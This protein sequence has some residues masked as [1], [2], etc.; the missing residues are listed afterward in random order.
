MDERE[1]PRRFRVLL[2]ITTLLNTNQQALGSF[3]R[4]VPRE[5]SLDRPASGADRAAP[6]VSP[7]RLRPRR[8]GLRRLAARVSSGRVRFDGRRDRAVGVVR[9]PQ[10]VAGMERNNPEGQPWEIDS[11]KRSPVVQAIAG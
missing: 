4:G 5:D 10:R 9:G 1:E 7:L 3:E 8:R 11:L 6:I 2:P